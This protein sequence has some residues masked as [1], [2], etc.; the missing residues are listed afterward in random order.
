MARGKRET[1][2][3]VL[4]NELDAL[5]EKR[6]Q[7]I[8]RIQ[9]AADDLGSGAAAARSWVSSKTPR[10]GGRRPGFKMSTEARAKIAAAQRKRWAKQ[11]ATEK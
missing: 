3:I 11:K 4:A 6:R 1:T 10:K 9:A 2:L 5:D 7:L 8:T